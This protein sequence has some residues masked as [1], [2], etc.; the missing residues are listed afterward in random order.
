[1]SEAGRCPLCGQQLY[2]WIALP[3]ADAEA[4]VGMTI[5]PADERVIDR[6]EE[7]GVA[8]ERGEAADAAAGGGGGCPTGEAG[9]KT[10]ENNSQGIL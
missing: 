1:M 8:L 3:A 2:G 10:K 7:C 6:C 9:A 5:N 4:S